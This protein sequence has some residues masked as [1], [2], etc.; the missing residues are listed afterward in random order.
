MN[1]DAMTTP[2]K[3]TES[4]AI[5][6]LV[7]PSEDEDDMPFETDADKQTPGIDKDTP[8]PE[9]RER[10]LS[11]VEVEPP[12][13]MAEAE[14]SMLFIDRCLLITRTHE[15]PIDHLQKDWTS[16]VYA[17]FNPIPTIQVIDGCHI[18]EVRCST[19]GC[20]ARIRRYLD[21]K[22]ARSTR[23]M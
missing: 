15:P 21:T 22:D 10:S 13:E 7:I 14:L 2:A 5:R 6:H 12:E 8:A 18:H 16:L 23:N 3:P 4:R 20:K 19:R 17:F 9:E 11:I 1:S